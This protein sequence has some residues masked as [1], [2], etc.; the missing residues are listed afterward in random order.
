MTMSN[1]GIISEFWSF[2]RTWKKWWI[3]LTIL[4]VIGSGTLPVFAKGSAL[5]IYSLS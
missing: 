5:V 2:L 4:F 1:F 3:A